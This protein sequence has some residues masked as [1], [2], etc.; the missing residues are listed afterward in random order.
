MSKKTVLV[1][2]AS[3]GIGKETAKTMIREGYT[4]YT[5]ARRIERMEDLFELGGI[6]IKMDITK[7]DE[8]VA[9]VEQIQRESG[10][11]DILINNAGF[12]TY[13]AV[14]DTPM[15]DARYQ[16]EVNLFGLARLTQLVLPYMR[17][18]RAGKIVNV[19]SAAG[20][21]YVPLGAWYIA[22]KH[23]LEGWSDC[24]RLETKPFNID[25]I[26]IEPGAIGTEFGDVFLEPMLKRSGKGPYSTM[27]N[28]FAKFSQDTLADPNG[29]SP[30]SVIANTIL[31]AIKSSRPGTRYVAGKLAKPMMFARKWFGDRFFDRVIEGAI[32]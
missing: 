23:A 6:P 14:E 17:E 32:R 10:G 24:L 4:V 27:T 22:T 29:S 18:K 26:I 20:K 3:S 11:V 8:V 19:S 9:A 15:D 13:G 30:P 16:F 2:G 31:K 5:A 21:V 25:V 12:A 7:D 1:T 28:A